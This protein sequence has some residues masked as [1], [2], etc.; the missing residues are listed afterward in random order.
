MNGA[1]TPLPRMSSCTPSFLCV[2]CSS[3]LVQFREGAPG[4]VH[5]TTMGNQLKVQILQPPLE[6]QY[7]PRS[8]VLC[9]D[10]VVRLQ[11]GDEAESLQILNV[12]RIQKQFPVNTLI[13][14]N[15]QSS[16]E[17]KERSGKEVR[18]GVARFQTEHTHTHPMLHKLGI[19]GLLCI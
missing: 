16:V 19:D 5:L 6:A 10:G 14:I 8:A 12:L 1:I 15:K 3:I 17:D 4:G 11:A 2:R 13:M 18:S 7:I 9:H